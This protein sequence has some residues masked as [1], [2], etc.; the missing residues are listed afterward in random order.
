MTP[1]DFGYQACASCSTQRPLHQLGP[2]SKA[3]L[4]GCGPSKKPSHFDPPKEF[5]P[6]AGSPSIDCP[7]GMPLPHAS[8]CGFTV[9]PE[10]T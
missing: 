2:I 7:C 3:C 4:H 5:L 9:D 6:H 8:A 10:V 1:G